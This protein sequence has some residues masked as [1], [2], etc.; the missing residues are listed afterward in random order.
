M[1]NPFVAQMKTAEAHNAQLTGRIEPVE[2][3]FIVKTLD[4]TETISI[5]RHIRK[6]AGYAKFDHAV[7]V[8]N[9]ERVNPD[10]EKRKRFPKSTYQ[11][12]FDK[13]RGICPDCDKPLDI[14]ATRNHIDHISPEEEDFNNDRNIRLVH[15]S[16]NLRKGARSV[17]DHA[18]RTGRSFEQII[19]TGNHEASGD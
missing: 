11:R 7:K 8:L 12:L 13:Q 4:Q 15:D 17:Y 3:P 9:R 18:K 16:C 10:R 2:M 14:P 5:L 6:L 19:G 1:T